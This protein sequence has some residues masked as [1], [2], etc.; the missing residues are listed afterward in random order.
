MRMH[1]SAKVAVLVVAFFTIP[2]CD[3]AESPITGVRNDVPPKTQWSA[4]PE[5][6][7][8]GTMVSLIPSA[9][10][11]PRGDSVRI[12][13]GGTAV[14]S[15]RDTSTGV[16]SFLM[17]ALAPG[18]ATIDLWVG[19]RA[20]GRASVRNETMNVDTPSTMRSDSLRVLVTA[21]IDELNGLLFEGNDT[22]AP[23]PEYVRLR[24][25]LASELRGM[26]T[27][28]E[29][30]PP[31]TRDSALALVSNAMGGPDA[32]G[33]RAARATATVLGTLPMS[34][35]HV[36][37]SAPDPVARCVM[38]REAIQDISDYADAVD[39]NV[40]QLLLAAVA[41]APATA[42]TSVPAAAFTGV[43]LIVTARVTTEFSKIAVIAKTRVPRL[44]SQG[45]SLFVDFS[46]ASGSIGHN[47]TPSVRLYTS[48]LLS[49]GV[50][51]EQ[52]LLAM[53]S[54][55]PLPFAGKI[56]RWVGRN[57][58]LRRWAGDMSERV[59]NVLASKVL[60]SFE[61]RMERILRTRA[62]FFAGGRS[63][64]M[65]AQQVAV[66]P[67]TGAEWRLT[68]HSFPNSTT[69]LS[70]QV[71]AAPPTSRELQF[72]PEYI[73]AVP[74]DYLLCLPVAAKPNI[75]RGENAFR[76]MSTGQR[77]AL[78]ASATSIAS[79]RGDVTRE[80]GLTVTNPFNADVSLNLRRQGL[81]ILPGTQVELVRETVQLKARQT[82][83]ASDP[84][85]PKLRVTIRP[86]MPAVRFGVAIVG[87]LGGHDQACTVVE[88]SVTAAGQLV[89]QGEMNLQF[90]GATPSASSQALA[91]V[92]LNGSS[93]NV[94]WQGRNLAA[95]P[96]SLVPGPNVLEIRLV[97]GT[98]VAAYVVPSPFGTG[99]P[100]SLGFIPH[101]MTYFLATHQPLSTP[102]DFYMSQAR[103][104]CTQVEQSR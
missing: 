26:L 40:L 49:T 83:R 55:I 72:Q 12:R 73:G 53:A 20:V 19:D 29:S 81:F 101:R 100:V 28:F 86:G 33:R 9:S 43:A 82:L 6:V 47:Q 45:G 96:V 91:R 77:V 16:V 8:L 80:I 1:D 67:S 85:A 64:P 11:L 56:A 94:S 39:Q 25:D 3:K 104:A 13:V 4:A 21:A 92:T 97:D 27:D 75:E 78:S 10:T 68:S 93:T 41:T 87:E 50:G 2:G 51:A 60:K 24:D 63:E 70:F 37:L 65:D 36:Q 84:L 34:S 35:S 46:P 99:K 23:D 32:L 98:G 22:G 54:A 30:L 14:A 88:V 59:Q 69:G 31:A 5:R 38:Q 57:T 102:A 95:F 7:S 58:A 90:S 48:M 15:L 44:A 76:L 79:E 17:P 103:Q 62:P 71:I 89:T 74:G 42:G 61:T 52:T 18:P 66:S